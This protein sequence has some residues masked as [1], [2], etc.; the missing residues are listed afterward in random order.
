MKNKIGYIIL[1][2]ITAFKT[3]I[4]IVLT[5]GSFLINC[6]TGLI[7]VMDCIIMVVNMFLIN[8]FT[9]GLSI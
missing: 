8:A 7:L 5:K 6:I 2:I 4:Q 9:Y 1:G 3:I